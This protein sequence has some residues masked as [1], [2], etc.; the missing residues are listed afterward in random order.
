[1]VMNPGQG[2]F[3][4]PLPIDNTILKPRS[5]WCF[6]SAPALFDYPNPYMGVGEVGNMLFPPGVPCP[7][8]YETTMV[9]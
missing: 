4:A 2:D 5:L 6:V 1:M 7:L 8:S 9:N 3:V